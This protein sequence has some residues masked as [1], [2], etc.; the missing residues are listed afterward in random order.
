MAQKRKLKALILPP[1]HFVVKFD[2]SLN[3][4][5]LFVCIITS[6]NFLFHGDKIKKLKN[7]RF[8]DETNI[9]TRRSL[10]S[11][12][13][14]INVKYADEVKIIVDVEYLNFKDLLRKRIY[15]ELENEYEDQLSKKG[16]K[17]DNLEVE[18][19]FMVK[20]ILSSVIVLKHTKNRKKRTQNKNKSVSKLWWNEVYYEWNDRDDIKTRNI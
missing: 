10:F 9:S 5:N 7:G 16:R 15:S 19:D 14:S 11:D 6:E 12:S 2:K 8:Y 1:V 4:N 3:V 13:S 20:S 18:N 17:N